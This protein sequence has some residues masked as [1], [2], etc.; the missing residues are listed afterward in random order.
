MVGLL[1]FWLALAGA[2]LFGLVA[3]SHLRHMAQ[4]DGQRRP[5]HA[6][7][8]LMALSMICMEAPMSATRLPELAVA[9][10]IALAGAGLLAALWAVWGTS[11]APNPVWLLTALDLGAM[12]YLWS[13]GPSGPAI[14]A[15][16]TLYLLADAGMW[17]FDSHRRWEREPSLLR[18]LPMGNS[19]GASVALPAGVARV[20]R[21][22]GDLDISPSMV[23]MSLAM[24]AM[25]LH[26]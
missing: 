24:A 6:C 18:W 7:H 4:T 21:L 17:A 19:P 9:W 13:P 23:L 8:V 26:A 16:V 2:V 11:G 12:L 14:S 15:A 10:R 20:D 1:P 5:W 3:L 25:V 22:L